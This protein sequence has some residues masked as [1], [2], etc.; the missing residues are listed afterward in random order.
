LSNKA[1]KRTESLSRKKS[2]ARNLTSVG[3]GTAQPKVFA[4]SLNAVATLT[5]IGKNKADEV[6]ES[7]KSVRFQT[8]NGNANSGNLS[9]AKHLT[10]TSVYHNA[11]P[12]PLQSSKRELNEAI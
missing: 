10:A 6:E 5:S 1:S 4:E 2:H 11:P 8:D 7:K 9:K 12:Q 3:V